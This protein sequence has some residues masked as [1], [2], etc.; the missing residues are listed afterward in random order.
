MRDVYFSQ[1]IPEKFGTGGI[2]DRQ[3]YF[4][5]L[6]DPDSLPA[7]LGLE[8][9]HFTC[10]IL[11]DGVATDDEKIG[12]LVVLLMQQGVVHITT[13]GPRCEHVADIIH[14][15]LVGPG[16]TIPRFSDDI[17]TFWQDHESL[18]TA[19]WNW[20]WV[21]YPDERYTDSCRSSIALS[22]GNREW[23]IPGREAAS[24]PVRFSKRVLDE[25]S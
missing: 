4:M 16:P 20:L 8:S 25:E 23:S 17:M 1:T 19:L 24:E 11:L 9:P 3:L 2:F 18:D 14:E 21:S 7:D 13:W 6:D 15:E 5:E 12:R 10:A 22:I